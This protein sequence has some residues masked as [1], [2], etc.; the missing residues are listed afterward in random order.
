MDEVL[1]NFHFIRPYWL[2]LILPLVALAIA[3]GLQMGKEKQ[4]TNLV[5]AHL[6]DFLMDP[7]T[8]AASRLP[9]FLA[10]LLAILMVIAAAG[11]TWKQLPQPVRQSV[12]A[13]VIV[14]DLSPSMN[15]AD[16][17]PSRLVRSRLKLIDLLNQRDEGLTGL[18]AYSGEAHVITP[19]TDDTRTIENML[20]GLSPEIMP[21]KGSNIEMAFKQAI[22]LLADSNIEQGDILIL[23]DGIAS[24]AIGELTDAHRNTNHRVTL[25]SIGTAEGAPIPVSNGFAR[26]NNNQIIVASVDFDRLSRVAVALNGL[27]VPHSSDDLDIETIQRFSAGAAKSKTLE[28]DRQFDQWQEFGPYFL[29]LLAPFAALAF[30]KGW[31]IAL[32]FSVN[33]LPEHKAYANTWNNLWQTQDQQAQNL[34]QEGDAQAAS[35]TFKNKDW[36]AIANYKNQNFDAAKQHFEQG[37]TAEDAFN[38]GNT[39]AHSGDYDGAINAYKEAL[40]RNPN[41]SEAA[42]NLKV[43]EKLKQ[44]AEQSQQQ[45][46]DN[47]QQGENQ[48]GE[49]SENSDSQQ[50]NNG[51]QQSG[52]NSES[53]NNRSEN[54]DSQNGDGENSEQ[55]SENNTSENNT[56][57]SN[58][59]EN[60]ASENNAKDNQQSSEAADHGENAEASEEEQQALE[61][62]YG[63]EEQNPAEDGA[64]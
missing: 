34:L 53:Q 45:N 55:A 64:G 16:V 27:F 60:N 42:D 20:A 40:N 44:L 36:Q 54:S 57:E 12:S 2:L 3:H 9:L 46:G 35:E 10:F 30:R 37:T 61:N 29:L 51:E 6:L 19:L 52:D 25:W 33:L 59:S 17:A 63:Q 23:T 58:A 1:N 56:S 14:W 7:N 21:Q 28:T 32:V 31:L 49:Q 5:D 26:D 11:P 47:N 13:T 24:D 4:W 48:N 22:Q 38:L 15:V 41:L 50:G 18:I 43:S 39:L 62:Q 8:K